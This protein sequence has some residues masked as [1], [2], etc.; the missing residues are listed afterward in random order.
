MYKKG[1]GEMRGGWYLNRAVPVSPRNRVWI[2]QLTL[3]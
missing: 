2:H 3:K 1:M